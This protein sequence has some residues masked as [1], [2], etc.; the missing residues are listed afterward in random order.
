MTDLK[1]L[2][3]RDSLL[4]L[5]GEKFFERGE[6]YHAQGTVELAY[7]AQ[8]ALIAKVSGTHPY[9]VEMKVGKDGLEAKCTC[10]AFDDFGVCKHIVAAGLALMDA[11][12]PA[13]PKGSL[14][15]PQAM[16]VTSIDERFPNI[17]GWVLDGNVEIGPCEYTDSFI[18]V[19]DEGGTVWEGKRKYRSLEHALADT[20]RAIK[21]WADENY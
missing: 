8:D 7:Y 3:T 16:P 12:N 20:E 15:P 17:A 14:M 6:A 21:E 18:R 4:E 19:T 9:L 1:S 2:I 5:A 11:G 10:P 13:H